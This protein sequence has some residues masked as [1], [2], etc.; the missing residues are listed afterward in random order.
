MSIP[1]KY[2]LSSVNGGYI[3]ICTGRY[4][5]VKPVW[6]VLMHGQMIA[7]S[8]Q[9]IHRKKL[10]TSGWRH[11]I[12]LKIRSRARNKF[13]RLRVLRFSR[14]RGLRK[15]FAHDLRHYSDWGGIDYVLNN[16]PRFQGLLT[17]VNEEDECCTNA[18]TNRRRS[19]QTS[20]GGKNVGSGLL[21]KTPWRQVYGEGRTECVNS[22]E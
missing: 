18:P 8:D 17:E 21:R 20:R 6:A 9:L 16:D 14:K 2:S 4:C 22:C 13:A 5:V 12:K 19:P 1:P 11:N 3:S 7:W 15:Y 10:L